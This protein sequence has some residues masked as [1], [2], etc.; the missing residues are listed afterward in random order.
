MSNRPTPPKKP[1]NNPLMNFLSTIFNFITNPRLANFAQIY[2]FLIPLLTFILGL[3]LNSSGFFHSLD[4]N[5]VC[6]SYEIRVIERLRIEGH[7]NISIETKSFVDNNSNRNQQM[8]FS[9]E[10]TIIE[11]ATK[12][13]TK[14]ISIELNPF[15]PDLIN[16]ID[17]NFEKK[18]KMENLCEDETIKKQM[19]DMSK[20]TEDYKK[21]K[22]DKI[23]PEKPELLKSKKGVYPV[24]RWVCNYKIIT[25]ETQK[26]N[27]QTRSEEKIDLN[28]EEYC[29]QKAKDEGDTGR[30]KPTHHNYRD[31]YSLYCVNPTSPNN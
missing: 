6:K 9:C 20:K 28:L 15:F 7:E 5:K 14:K 4:S 11:G 31:P 29:I 24:F 22:G 1:S 21:E 16:D 13:E 19:E 23:V 2:P 8:P 30:V 26:N 10:Y 17:D 27:F 12:L 3:G 18:I 25:K